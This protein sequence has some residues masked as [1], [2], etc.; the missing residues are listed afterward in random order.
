MPSTFAEHEE[1][2]PTGR[3]VNSRTGLPVELA[4]QRLDVSGSVYPVGGLLRVTHQFKIAGDQPV[5]CLYVSMLPR[6]GALRR[7]IIK[8]KDFEVKSE[9]QAR[10]KAR[11]TYEAGTA[12]GHLS[13]LAESDKDGLVTLSVGQIQPDDEVTVVLEVVTGVELRDDGFRVRYPFTIAPSFH[14]KAHATSDG[15]GG[16]SM[17]LPQDVFGDLILPPWKAGKDGMHEVGFNLHF[18]P[19]APIKSVSSPSHRVTFSV[20][21]DGS[22][23]VALDAKADLPN[24]DLVLEV[25]TA[26]AIKV[27]YADESLLGATPGE[28]VTLPK[29]APRWLAV[30]SST[31]AGQQQSQKR[32]VCFLLDIS[33]SMDGPKMEGMR[34][35]AMGC[36]G[37]LDPADEFGIVLFDDASHKFHTSL[38]P[39]TDANRAKAVKF[40]QQMHTVGGTQLMQGLGET[41]NV[42]GGPGGDIFLIT[43]GEVFE[44]GPI[45][46]Q[47]AASGTRVHTLGINTA[48]QDRFLAS[49]ARRTGGTSMMVNP[50]EDVAAKAMSLFATSKA[51]LLTDVTVLVNGKGGASAKY[52]TIWQGLPIVVYDPKVGVLPG[53]IRLASNGQ[54]VNLTLGPTKALPEGLIALLWGAKRV[55]DLEAT[56]DM[57][58]TGPLKASIEQEMATISMGY[59]LASRAASLVAVVERVGDQPGEMKQ[60]MAPIGMPEDEGNVFDQRSALR[61]AT[62]GVTLGASSSVCYAF[63]PASHTAPPSR[64]WASRRFKSSLGTKSSLVASLDAEETDGLDMTFFEASN[65]Q[66]YACDEIKVMSAADA[67]AVRPGFNLNATAKTTLSVPTGGTADLII[68]A[69]QMEAD[70]GL[71]GTTLERRILQTVL[72][73]LAIL[74]GNAAG[75][76]CLHLPRL[77]AFLEANIGNLPDPSLLQGAIDTLKAGTPPAVNFDWINAL[78]DLRQNPPQEQVEVV[79]SNVSSVR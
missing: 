61:C 15:A 60:T 57:A 5:E 46:E 17:E 45:I 73:G 27:V 13:A 8:G 75:I 16:G 3:V 14:E 58:T 62:R 55:E 19:G 69:A 12:A 24:R 9:L 7:F 22:A 63:A 56:F 35:A 74:Q 10:Q 71:P 44:T 18:D 23:D 28:A 42:L 1:R 54:T 77:I 50:S 36:L 40:L 64:A 65:Q 52:G 38:V 59:G 78:A 66:N 47:M 11:Q 76:F 53:N 72:F 20:N 70:G 48:S 30:F 2:G 21:A 67:Q 26:E 39:A 31:E 49:L 37:A 33:G 29:D 43:D 32:R 68:L 79:W 41:V 25:K 4:M 6:G 51:P 34:V